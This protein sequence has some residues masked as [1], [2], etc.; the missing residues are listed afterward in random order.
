MKSLRRKL[1]EVLQPNKSNYISK[2]VDLVIISIIFIN[3]VTIILS[4]VPR[5][6]SASKMFN[7]IELISIIIFSIE[8]ILR[9]WVCIED[10]KYNNRFSY[11]FSFYALVDLLSI[12]PF[13]I[14]KII[15]L[16]LRILRIIRFVRVFRLFKMGRY[17][18]GIQLLVTVLKKHSPQLLVVIFV[19]ILL[20]LVLSSFIFYIENPVQP[21]T[22]DSI[23]STMWWGIIT[24]T[25]VG[26]GD[27]YPVTPLG[28]I[29]G[30]IIAFM[31]V[32]LFSLPAGILG[33]GL[34]EEI[35]NNKK[36]QK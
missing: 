5:F 6:S 25:T 2:T 10:C 1:F 8:Y 23:P 15:K 20:L 12:L 17:S 29:L 21:E 26:Y 36:A 30:G 18:K 16:D 27:M 31:G 4:S 11:I 13:Y 28:K 35:R 3:V 33:A 9:V 7:I 19:A 32:G 34:L 14:P 22:F 24:M